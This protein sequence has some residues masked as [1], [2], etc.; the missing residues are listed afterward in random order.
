MA[1]VGSSNITFASLRTAYNAGGE[2]D[3]TGDANLQ[4]G[5]IKL[6][7]FRG[8]GFTDGSS[9]PSSGEI[10]VNDDFAGKTFGSSGPSTLTYTTDG[11]R[12][13]NRWS[14]DSD[15]LYST[16]ASST[17][18]GSGNTSNRRIKLQYQDGPSYRTMLMVPGNQSDSSSNTFFYV[19]RNDSN[20][21]PVDEA[22]VWWKEVSS[23]Y[24]YLHQW[25]IIA[26]DYNMSWEDQISSYVNNNH[27][28]IKDRMAFHGAG[29]ITHAGSA[30][31]I[32]SS[33]DLVEPAWEANKTYETA[34]KGHSNRV[35]SHSALNSE[36]FDYP[37]GSYP[38]NGNGALSYGTPNP[39]N[40]K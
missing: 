34:S 5:S 38:R 31:Y 24:Y 8:A 7:D 22:E 2:D 10:S 3:A 15:D 18:S 13:Y 29:Y 40:N 14:N 21:T 33:S 9:V 28:A 17:Y 20:V 1:S 39:G 35:S 32:T 25:G 27:A 4:S 6:A 37:N 30:D 16:T 11:F 26:K 36:A 12:V 23:D 19:D